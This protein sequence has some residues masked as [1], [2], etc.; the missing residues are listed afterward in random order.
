MQK[1]HVN[2]IW[3][4]FE[5]NL[6]PNV[7][8]NTKMNPKR[9]G[10]KLDSNWIQIWIQIGFKLDS[11]GHFGFNLDSI[12]IQ[13][14][15]NLDSLFFQWFPLCSIMIDHDRSWCIRIFLSFLCVNEIRTLQFRIIV[16]F[17]F[18]NVYY[19][20]LTLGL[21]IHLHLVWHRFVI[22]APSPLMKIHIHS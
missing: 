21:M 13:F 19:Y 9:I 4:Q 20:F 3:I 5:S 17:C 8:E 11:E 22:V 6:N 12:W 15:F 2:P 14:G 1:K 16:S 10:F 18:F 7:A